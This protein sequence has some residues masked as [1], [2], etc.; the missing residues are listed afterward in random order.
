[1]I[2]LEKR[3][4]KLLVSIHGWSSIIMGLL[5]YAVVLTGTIAVLATEIGY[6]SASSPVQKVPF[7]YP[8]NDIVQRLSKKVG[9]AYREDVSISTKFDGN[10][11]VFFH[12]HIKTSTGLPRDRGVLFIVNRKTGEVISRKE[13]T[14]LEIRN[15]NQ[16]STLKRF[17]VDTHVRLYMP[18]PWGLLVTGILGLVM[19][20]SA[21]TGLFIHRHLIRDIFTLRKREKSV[22]EK[23]DKHSVAASWGLPF[24]FLLAF[25]GCFF[26][27]AGSFGIPALAMVAFGGNRAELIRTIMGAN[28]VRPGRRI[29]TNDLDKMLQASQSRAGAIARNLKIEH[30]GRKNA[31]VT[32]AHKPKFGGLEGKTLQYHGVDGTF[33]RELPRV[34]VV[35]SMGAK[36]V[37]VIAPL[38]FGNF[39]GIFSKAIWVALGFSSCYIILSGLSLWTKRREEK[40]GWR[41][42]ERIIHV[43]GL[44]L[45]VAMASSAVAYFLF[46][47]TPAVINATPLGFLFGFCLVLLASLFLSSRR[48][49]TFLWS[50]LGIILA[51]LPA[52]RFLT[53]E[54]GWVSALHQ[55]AITVIAVDLLFVFSSFL[56]FWIGVKKPVSPSVPALQS[57]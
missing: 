34:G 3:E 20:L 49:E 46:F 1:M 14:G 52:F 55:G 30:F 17:L 6:W 36:I 24:A 47:G 28:F 32:I 18:M 26:S 13:A 44:G 4:T 39:A 37:T 41:I 29:I 12:K 42:F 8:I 5:L 21:V 35:P 45:P 11:S 50:V 19:M 56:C 10:L 33:K 16:V 54:L 31:V 51:L 7:S 2:P 53:S 57:S 38:H 43:F 15:N 25:T 22:L 40:T 27:F 9:R 23:R 48:L